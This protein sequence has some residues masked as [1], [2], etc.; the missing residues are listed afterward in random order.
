MYK[1]FCNRSLQATSMPED[2]L[3]VRLA[4]NVFYQESGRR[5]AAERREI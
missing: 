1:L 4:I 2:G 5:Q 3:W